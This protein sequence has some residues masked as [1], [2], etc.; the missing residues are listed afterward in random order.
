[1]SRLIG[2]LTELTITE[3]GEIAKKFDDIAMRQAL[4]NLVEE[5]QGRDPKGARINLDAPVQTLRSPMEPTLSRSRRQHG[6]ERSS[7]FATWRLRSLHGA[8]VR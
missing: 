5:L 3:S 1:V 7:A 8:T 4:A 2:Q 6:R